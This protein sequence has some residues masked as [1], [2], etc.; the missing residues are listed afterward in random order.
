MMRTRDFAVMMTVMAFLVVAISATWTAGISGIGSLDTRAAVLVS[1][2]DQE[3]SAI[4]AEPGGTSRADRLASLREKVARTR[5]IAAFE[6]EP[7]AEEVT[8]VIETD[9]EDQGEQRCVGYA[10]KSIPWSSDGV[11]IQ[12]VEGARLVFTETISPVLEAGTSTV[13][14]VTPTRSIVAQLP[15]K[16]SP[17]QSSACIPSDVVGISQVGSLIRNNEMIA[18][19]GRG[20][21]SL[22][23]YALDGFPIYG[24]LPGAE[25]DSCGGRYVNGQYRYQLSSERDT[26]IDCFA[27]TPIT[28]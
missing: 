23:G 5:S 7:E 4:V 14:V 18:Y 1:Q 11:T 22:I 16:S 27:G 6:P 28:L 9:T 15:L 10:R 12:E 13:P 19:Q 20:P 2:S 8:V 24:I 21:E 3:Y 17:N 25:T 26:L